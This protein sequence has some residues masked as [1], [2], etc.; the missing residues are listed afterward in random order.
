MAESPAQ[1][2]REEPA[3]FRSGFVPVA[4][5]PGLL[6]QPLLIIALRPATISLSARL[7]EAGSRTVNLVALV[8]A[9]TAAMAMAI[10]LLFPNRG[11]LGRHVMEITEQ[12]LREKTDMNDTLNEWSSICRVLSLWGYL[13]IY[14]SEMKSYQVPERE[15][16]PGELEEFESEVRQR[17]S[18]AR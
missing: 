13:Y 14:I 6:A 11:I 7:A 10:T 18:R 12:G 1:R 4:A 2:S 5:R 3:V 17:A 8:V 15:L 9:A 16:P